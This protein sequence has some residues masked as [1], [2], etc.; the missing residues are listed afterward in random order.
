MRAAGSSWPWACRSMKPGATTRP[1]TSSTR[2]PL[3]GFSDTA[4]I[5]PSL[6]PTWRTASRPD[7]GSMTRPLART[8]SSSP[9][10]AAPGAASV[11]VSSSKAAVVDFM[12]VLLPGLLRSLAF[13]DDDR[14]QRAGVLAHQ[15]L[16]LAGHLGV[17]LHL[18]GQ[19]PGPG[20]RLLLE[21]LADP[22]VR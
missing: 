8:R 12:S 14:P 22:C 11:P 5:L 1:R 10:G 4:A 21:Q 7:S 18:L 20:R 17:G 9:P 19:R 15:G 2:L 13:A 16:T 6:M 3:S